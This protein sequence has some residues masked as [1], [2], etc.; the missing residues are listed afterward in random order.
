MRRRHK[1]FV[2]IVSNAPGKQSSDMD[3]ISEQ[4]VDGEADAVE[5]ACKKLG[6]GTDRLSVSDPFDA[7]EKLRTSGADIVF[8]LCEGLDGDS[9]FEM[10]FAAM[11]ELTGIPFT[12]ARPL[13][14]GLARNK[15]LAKRVM[16]AAGIRVPAGVHVFDRRD[17]VLG[18]LAFPLI[19]KPAC[20]DASL[21][22]YH[23]SVVR[24][25]RALAERV[26]A[27]LK[28]YPRDGILVEEYVDGREFNC[29]VME[30]DGRPFLLE[31]S[32][33][34][35]SGLPAGTDHVTGYEAK[36]MEDSV[37]FKSTPPH[38]PIHAP[39]A[40]KRKIRSTAES[41]WNALGAG[42]YG[43]V[44]MRCSRAGEIYVLEYNPN[45][46]ITPGAGF[47]KGLDAAK[48]PYHEFV[49]AMIETALAKG[50]EA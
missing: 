42:G 6:F 39:A 17:P 47:S 26:N 19:C 38:C 45:P 33:I 18:K 34:D 24:S 37:F 50:G 27:L 1:L 14:L 7:V 32:E 44:D 9:A 21:G 22:I 16:S 29:A 28:K 5:A 20:E 31:P 46:D 15:P 11:L 36:W 49:R 3:L 10:N 48:I 2:S 12:G 8:N 41:V 35:F 25:R 23:D 30:K 43:R 13:L 4:G 40:L